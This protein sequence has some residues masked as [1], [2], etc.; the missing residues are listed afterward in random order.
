M[1]A[2]APSIPP[3]VVRFDSPFILQPGIAIGLFVLVLFFCR[4]SI[5]SAGLDAKQHG[6]LPHGQ[7][8]RRTGYPR[9]TQGRILQ[10]WL[11]KA[12]EAFEAF[13]SRLLC[14][15]TPSL[16]KRQ[17]TENFRVLCIGRHRKIDLC[18]RARW[19]V[20]IKIRQMGS[21]LEVPTSNAEDRHFLQDCPI[22]EAPDGVQ[23][24]LHC[25]C[26]HGSYCC[27]S[28]NSLCNSHLGLL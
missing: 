11:L 23:W 15:I 25:Q 4:G 18:P 8:Q 20:R 13:G 21:Q 17:R 7:L 9:R 26:R 1:V 27:S 14:Q 24:P 2:L 6:C 10:P 28:R 22:L 16:A 12:L 19:H 5:S 3:V